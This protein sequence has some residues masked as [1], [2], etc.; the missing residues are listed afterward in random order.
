MLLR[1]VYD[2]EQM[3]ELRGISKVAKVDM[4]LLVALNVLLD[5]LMGCT[6]GGAMI[7]D[8]HGDTRMM[9]FRVL[10]WSMDLLRDVVVELQYVEYE[11]GPVVATSVT[12]LGFVGVLTGVRY[13]L[14]ACIYLLRIL[15]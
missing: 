1:R 8:G 12:F 6:S 4:Y 9:H 14:L 11:N 10:D 7:Q 15:L 5:L 13:A 2:R 3:R